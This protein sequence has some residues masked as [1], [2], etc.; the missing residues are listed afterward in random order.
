MLR[1]GA[2]SFAILF[3]VSFTAGLARVQF[4]GVFDRLDDLHVTGA[5]ADIA[6]ERGANIVLA[7]GRIAA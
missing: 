3:A 1:A 4:G 5:A 7:R 6:A 2:I